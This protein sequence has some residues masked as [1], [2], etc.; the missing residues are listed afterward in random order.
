MDQRPTAHPAAV[1]GAVD[2]DHLKLGLAWGAERFRGAVCGRLGS[3]GIRFEQDAIALMKVHGWLVPAGRAEIGRHRD[4]F[5][6]IAVPLFAMS[7][8]GPDQDLRTIG[9]A[10]CDAQTRP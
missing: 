1:S 4:L 10:P 5:Y 9:L 6:R 2:P 7:P 8:S 3:E